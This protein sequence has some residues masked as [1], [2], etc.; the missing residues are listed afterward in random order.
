MLQIALIWIV[1]S[2]FPTIHTLN[3]NGDGFEHNLHDYYIKT[4]Y[5]ACSAGQFKNDF[6]NVRFDKLY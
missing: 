3:I 5:N 4:A 2:E 6:V 1:Y